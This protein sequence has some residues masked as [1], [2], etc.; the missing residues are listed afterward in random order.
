MNT[1]ETFAVRPLV[2]H[3]QDLREYPPFLPYR[4]RQGLLDLPYLAVVLYPVVHERR[5][6][7]G[8]Y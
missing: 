8:G 3:Y 2:L 5:Y 4:R 6:A 1:A 7:I